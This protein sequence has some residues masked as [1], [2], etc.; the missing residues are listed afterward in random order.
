MDFD[1]NMLLFVGGILAAGVPAMFGLYQVLLTTRGAAQKD[2]VDN[3]H[4]DIIALKEEVKQLKAEV[5]EGRRCSDLLREEAVG[6][7]ADAAQL[8]SEADDLRADVAT[9]EDHIRSLSDII[10]KMGG[11]APPMPVL[12]RNG[13]RAPK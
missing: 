11:S 12:R 3:L 5:A 4:Q 1:P 10:A 2:Y 9:L 13:R 7:R 6:L 8:R